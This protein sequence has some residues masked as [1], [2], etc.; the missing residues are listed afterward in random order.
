MLIECDEET[1][2]KYMK[3]DPVRPELFDDDGTR[4]NGNFRV[5]ADV[6]KQGFET[7]VNAIICVVIIPFVPQN[8]KHLRDIASEDLKV[9]M[10]M[11]WE[12][13]RFPRPNDEEEGMATILCP[14]SLWSYTKGAGRKLVNELLEAIPFLHPEVS[15]VV[16]MSPPTKM[17]MNFHTSNGAFLL[18]PNK[19]TV[20][21]EYKYIPDCEDHDN[22][23]H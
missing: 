8:E 18:S 10:A 19:D 1:Y 11:E 16:T 2:G 5:Y 17:A 9:L 4:F 6:D 14:Y 13:D 7:V 21:Y 3:D 20:N 12:G 22:T 15:H 23:I